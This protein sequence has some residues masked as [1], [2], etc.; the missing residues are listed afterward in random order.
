MADDLGRLLEIDQHARQRS[1]A[2]LVAGQRGAPSDPLKRY[3]PGY[4]AVV[5]LQRA[6]GLAVLV[7]WCLAGVLTLLLVW[8]SASSGF[9]GF[10]V[11]GLIPAAGFVLGGYAVSFLFSALAAFGNAMLDTA[12]HTSPFLD[13][14]LKARAMGLTPSPANTR[15]Q[16]AE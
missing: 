1:A 15:V 14:A 8:E 10:L 3:Q 12:I 6:A 5:V 9:F 13:S 7:G 11:L 4:A 16:G 2:G